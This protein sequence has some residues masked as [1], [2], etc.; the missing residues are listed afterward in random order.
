[1]QLNAIAGL[2]RSGST[3]LCN[4]LNQND[5]FYA[6]TTSSLCNAFNSMIIEMSSSIEFKSLLNNDREGTEER[7]KNSVKSFSDSWYSHLEK[8]II[9]DKSRGWIH[10]IEIL[11]S[12]YKESKMIVIIRDLRNVFASIEKQNRKT[13]LFRENPNPLERT[14]YKRADEMFSPQGLIGHCIVGIEDILN[15]NLSS[16]AVK[17]VHDI[18]DAMKSI[19]N[20]KIL[21]I[22]YEQLADS[23]KLF[24]KLIYN[25]L[26][27]EEFEHDFNNIENTSEDPDGFYLYKFPH[28]GE[29]QIK[30]NFKEEWRKF[31]SPGIAQLIVERFKWYYE[32][33]GYPFGQ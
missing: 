3:L 25:F 17:S 29:G 22:K 21:F 9:F 14:I 8:D 11:Q 28:K 19:S 18:D 31:M 26:K 32:Y 20:K 33:F 10:N 12:L 6:S 23:P 16:L 7:F 5:K 24:M 1:M 15:K 4:I 27:Q 2:P 30:E 13:P